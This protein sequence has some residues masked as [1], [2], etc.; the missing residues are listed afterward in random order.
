MSFKRFVA[1]VT[2]LVVYFT[3]L[4][5]SSK[6]VPGQPALLYILGLHAWQRKKELVWILIIGKLRFN[7]LHL[8]V[9]VCQHVEFLYIGTRYTFGEVL[10]LALRRIF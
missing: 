10:D 1:L 7:K 9:S 4:I 2:L 3:P 6:L 5:I 8:N